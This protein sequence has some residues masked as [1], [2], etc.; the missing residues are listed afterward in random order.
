MHLG[1]GIICPYTGITMLAISGGFLFWSIK[2]LKAKLLPNNILLPLLLT[3]LVFSLQM[4]NF[5]IPLTSSS[6][7]IVGAVLL[8]ILLGPKLAFVAMFAILLVQSVFFADGGLLA[9]GCNLFNMGVLGCFVAYPLFYKPI[10]KIHRPIVASVVASV[11]ALQLASL[12]VVLETY[13]SGAIIFSVSKFTSLMLGIH[14]VIALVEGIFTALFVLIINKIS[15][16]FALALLAVVSFVSATF[17]AQ[18]ASQKPDGLEW[19]LIKISDSLIMQNHWNIY[20]FFDALQ[21]KLAI[22]SKIPS[23]WANIIGIFV[24]AFLSLVLLIT[25]NLPQKSYE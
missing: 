1:N 6:G 4:I 11:V 7:H 18:Y 17:L 15:E 21:I 24:V 5:P 9:F 25:L 10:E 23:L 22:L 12:A 14:F 2:N 13:F 20:H 8:S 3:V 16:K 19:A